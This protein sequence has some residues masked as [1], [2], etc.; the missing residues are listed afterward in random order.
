M[1]N[2]LKRRRLLL[3]VAA[4]IVMA[5]IFTSVTY[6][7]FTGATENVVNKFS[8]GSVETEIIEEIV[9]LGKKPSV[10]NCGQS[11][12]LVRMRV[13]ISP[14]DTGI[15]LDLPGSDWEKHGEFYYYKGVL[16]AGG[17]TS[18]LFTTVTLPDSWYEQENPQKAILEE[19]FIPFE[20]GLY[21]E[22]VQARVYDENG[23]VVSAFTVDEDGNK[24]FHAKNAEK[25]WASFDAVP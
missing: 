22:A 14:N 19:R 23:A 9:D 11:D 7:F 1:K 13:T 10:K 8:V 5:G 12:C 25:I 4:A 20:I 21:Q 18:P 15:T 2:L 17:V 16:P 3:A 24:V 6:A